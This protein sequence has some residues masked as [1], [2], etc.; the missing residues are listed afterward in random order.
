MVP[1]EI[2]R[3][4]AVAI[5]GDSSA[6]PTIAGAPAMDSRP[7]PISR[8]AGCSLISRGCDVAAAVAV[9]LAE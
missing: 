6:P 2:E 4:D 1:D 8:A 3:G 5:A 7:T 9:I